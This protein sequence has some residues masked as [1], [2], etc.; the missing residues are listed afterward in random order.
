MPASSFQLPAVGCRWLPVAA[1]GR[2]GCRSPLLLLSLRTRRCCGRCRCRC[3]WRCALVAAV[4]AVAAAVGVTATA[5]VTAAAAAVAGDCG[6]ECAPATGCGR[7][8]ALGDGV[9]CA[10]V[11]PWSHGCRCRYLITWGVTVVKQFGVCAGQHCSRGAVWG[12]GVCAGFWWG[13]VWGW[14][15]SVRWSAL[16]RCPG[17]DAGRGVGCWP[18][19]WVAAGVGVSS[20]GGGCCGPR[21]VVV[22]RGGAFLPPR[23]AASR[24][25]SPPPPPVVGGGGFD[26]SAAIVARIPGASPINRA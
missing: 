18:R 19:G 17:W 2:I 20:A 23:L 13:L 22:T 16:V 3:R 4:A 21:G 6:H 14:P 24:P 1:G 11:V 8:C 10:G 7:G 26:A 15:V 25:N 9:P 12:Q 5:T